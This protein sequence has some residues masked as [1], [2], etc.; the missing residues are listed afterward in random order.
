[1]DGL[2]GGYR[3][4]HGEDGG[5]VVEA[6]TEEGCILTRLDARHR[7]LLVRWGMGPRDLVEVLSEQESEE[8]KRQ[9]YH[10]Q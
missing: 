1:M 4:L 8:I 6:W 2:K 3:C 9:G 10:P 7:R 5:A